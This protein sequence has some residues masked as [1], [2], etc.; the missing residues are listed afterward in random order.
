[1]LMVVCHSGFRRSGCHWGFHWGCCRCSVSIRVSFGVVVVVGAFVGVSI[2]VSVRVVGIDATVC[3]SNCSARGD[4]YH[5]IYRRDLGD[6]LSYHRDRSN[7]NNWSTTLSIYK[8]KDK[9]GAVE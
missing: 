7:S 9:R 4:E 5:N 3:D 6:T 2:R 1:M 8:R